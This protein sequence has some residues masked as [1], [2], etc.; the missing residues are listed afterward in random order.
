MSSWVRVA[1]AGAVA[2][3][4]TLRVEVAGTPVCLARSEGELFAVHDT[5]THADVSLSEG[6][7][8]DCRVECWLHGSQFDLRTGEPTGLPAV[9]AVATYA[10]KS[11]AGGIF[12]DL[13]HKPEPG[14]AVVGHENPAAPAG[15]VKEQI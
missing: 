1:D 5:C 2:D 9:T 3:E 4:H 11:E 12:V 14:D 6:E 13:T 10:V 7:V 15:A 8:E